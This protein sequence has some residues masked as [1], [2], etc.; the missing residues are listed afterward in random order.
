MKKL[1]LTKTSLVGIIASVI[2]LTMTFTKSAISQAN[3]LAELEKARQ[4]MEMSIYRNDGTTSYQLM[5]FLTCKYKKVGSQYKAASKP[6]RKV[7]ENISKDTG[8]GGRD[9]ISLGRIIEPVSDRNMA[10]LQHDYDNPEKDVDQWMYFPAMKKLKR[11]ISQSQ[12]SPKTGSVFGTEISYEDSERLQLSEYTFSLLDQEKIDGR[13]CDVIEAFPTKERY[14]ETSYS[15]QK[16]WVDLTSKIVMKEELYDKKG[17]LYKTVYRKK[18]KKY[19]D[20]W[21]STSNIIVNHDSG[22]MSMLRAEKVS[23]NIPIDDELFEKRALEDAA[24]REG[25][26]KKIRKTTE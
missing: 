10:F 24:F 26:M 2:L 22:F 5:T 14:P 7:I 17:K 21:L 18:L 13:M 3:D 20:I 11:I 19:G 15:F 25:K 16:K 4:I 6:I 12:N 1:N 8:E 9:M 23:L